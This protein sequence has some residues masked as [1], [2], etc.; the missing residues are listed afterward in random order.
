MAEEEIHNLNGDDTW[1]K[2]PNP[3]FCARYAVSLQTVTV[4]L[5]SRRVSLRRKVKPPF[6]M[7]LSIKNKNRYEKKSLELVIC[8]LIIHTQQTTNNQVMILP[9]PTPPNLSHVS[10]YRSQH[11]L[12][13]SHFTARLPSWSLILGLLGVYRVR[14]LLSGGNNCYERALWAAERWAFWLIES[15]TPGIPV[16]HLVRALFKPSL[17]FFSL[18]HLVLFY[19]I[20]F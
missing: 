19:F 11:S 16:L 17:L 1:I 13:L 2:F 10:K 5:M 18:P 20:L 3:L 7:C 8:W 12:T 4:F 15:E 6:W 14:H 9:P